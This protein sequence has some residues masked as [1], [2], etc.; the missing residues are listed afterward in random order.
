MLNNLNLYYIFYEVAKVGNISGAA[1][2]LFISQ[3]AIS[4]AISKLEDN[5]GVV[6]FNR[7]S[8]GVSLTDEG[9]ILFEQVH[10]AFLCIHNGEDKIRLSNELGMGH[11]SIGVSTSLCKHILLPSLKQ[12]TGNNPHIKVSISCQSSTDT[13]HALENGLIDIGVIGYPQNRLSLQY[14]PLMEIHDAFVASPS[15]LLN[16][17]KRYDS[18]I[19]SI[20]SNAT[21]MMLNKENISR[22][23]VDSALAVNNLQIQNIMEVTN[24]DLLIEF[25]KTDL[26][27]SAVIR[28]FVSEELSNETLTEL[29]LY[30]NAPGREIGIAYSEA[31]AKDN[32][33]IGHFL[34]SCNLV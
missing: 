30:S 17:E 8:R 4:K 24:L 11:I 15:Y 29:T 18:S 12:F 16:F 20:L 23:Y 3:P 27:I 22:K 6:L 7:S 14:K 34:E 13:I 32:P 2:E 21:F 28:E 10:N 33:A 31:K 19:E 1:K 25:A 9:L 26:G 5:L